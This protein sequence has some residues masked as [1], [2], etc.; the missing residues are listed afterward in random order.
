MVAARRDLKCPRWT[1]HKSPSHPVASWKGQFMSDTWQTI[2]QAAVTLGLS[3]RTV[4]RHITGGK[5]ESRLFEGR[6]EVRVTLAE[7]V[8]LPR[9]NGSV[10]GQTSSD[11]S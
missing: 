1:H 3:V 7:P 4:N 6:R 10:T 8:A 5:L 2:E 9:G 11:V